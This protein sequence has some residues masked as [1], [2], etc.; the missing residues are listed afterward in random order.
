MKTLQERDPF[1]D[2]LADVWIPLK[3]ILKKVVAMV[4]GGY[5][6]IQNRTQ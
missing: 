6:F 4:W 3:W 5:S 1:D 2:L